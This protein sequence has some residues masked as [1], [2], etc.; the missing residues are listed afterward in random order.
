MKPIE[1][2]KALVEITET[3][4]YIDRQT[5]RSSNKG[6]AKMYQLV[7]SVAREG[8]D[9]IDELARLLDDPKAARWLAHQLVECTEL[10]KATEEKCFAIIEE[11]SKKDG[12]GGM[13]EKIWLKEWK[14]KKG[15]T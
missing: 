6:V 13:G 9:A 8:P 5:I 4:D 12:P 7:H 2:Y 11:L 10:P 1:E 15:R 14:P 3:V